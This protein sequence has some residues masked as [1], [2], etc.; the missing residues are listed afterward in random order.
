LASSISP[1]ELRRKLNK[2]GTI[3]VDVRQPSEFREG[4]I[5]KAKLIPSSSLPRRAGDLRR[6]KE[7]VVVC[8]SGSRSSRA[9]KQLAEMGFGNVRNLTGGM[10]AWE[11][12]GF[13]VEKK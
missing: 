1:G 13:P 7:I 6:F 5:P 10:N 9:A 8:R 11:R 4:H 12:A 3:I 2:S